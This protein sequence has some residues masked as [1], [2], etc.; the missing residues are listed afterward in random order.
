MLA[1]RS[2]VAGM[3]GMARWF[4]R[5]SSITAHLAG[6]YVTFAVAVALIIVWAAS[7]PLFAFSQTWQL[8]INTGTTIVTFLM[9]FLI[10]NTQNRD[11][12][13]LHVKLDEIIRALETTDN[14]VMSAEEDTDEQLEALHGQYERLS[15]APHP[16]GRE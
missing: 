16:R 9:V 11:S 1:S 6:H 4:T 2:A 14:A 10:Q 3:N 12:K 7:G 5:F 13:A 15:H 8:V